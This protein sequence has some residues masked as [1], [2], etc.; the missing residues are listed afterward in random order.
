[1]PGHMVN[2]E[3]PGQFWTCDIIGPLNLSSQHNKYIINSVC[4][5][6]KI[7]AF[8][9]VP[10]VTAQT[11][12]QFFEEEIFFKYGIPEQII[13]DNGPQ[14]ISQLLHSHSELF[15]VQL[16][17]TSLYNS[18]S[19]SVVERTNQ[20]V[21]HMIKHY[22]QQKYTSWD[23]ELLI[24][25]HCYNTSPHVGL[26]NKSPY[27]IMFGRPP[28]Y[29]NEFQLSHDK[30]HPYDI[31]E[32][33]N[34]LQKI[35]DFVRLTLDRQQEANIQREQKGH[36]PVSYSIGDIITLKYP[37]F[38][39]KQPGSSQKWILYF[40]GTYKILKQYNSLVYQVQ[41]LETQRTLMA[42]VRRMR[43]VQTYSPNDDDEQFDI[44]LSRN[45]FLDDAAH[46]H[47]T[48][49]T[50]QKLEIPSLDTIPEHFEFEVYSVRFTVSSH[51]ATPT[52]LQSL[53]GNKHTR[54]LV[55]EA[56]GHNSTQTQTLFLTHNQQQGRHIILKEHFSIT[57]LLD[58]LTQYPLSRYSI[59]ASDCKNDRNTPPPFL[60]PLSLQT[61]TLF[62]SYKTITFYR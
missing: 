19:N 2:P 31:M 43:R 53:E 33:K 40:F 48:C 18:C 12:A 49:S 57:S 27:E 10:N 56:S 24:L 46:V 62:S 45:E 44:C 8:R 52:H 51:N 58:L 50:L 32:R 60:L 30:D 23:S 16:R 36:R 28:K 11:V 21:A 34:Q 6:S 4:M 54:L 59:Y 13:L 38:I 42:H 55:L 41:C 26:G 9:A 35:W 29:P 61:P 15:Q 1:M 5:L 20:S 39:N 7:A 3:Y 22:V 14:F 25:N 47:E 17:H 37:Q